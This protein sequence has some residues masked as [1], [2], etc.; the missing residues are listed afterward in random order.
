MNDTEQTASSGTLLADAPATSDQLG[1]AYQRIAQGLAKLIRTSQGGKCVRLDGDWGAGKSTVIAM[2]SGLLDGNEQERANSGYAVFQFDAWV[3]AGD[4]LKLAFLRSLVDRLHDKGWLNPPSGES[5]TGKNARQAWNH[6]LD[7][8]AGKVKRTNETSNTRF[9][10]DTKVGVGFVLAGLA[11]WSMLNE[12]VLRQVKDWKGE[13]GPL[14]YVLLLIFIVFACIQLIPGRLLSLAVKLQADFKETETISDG[15]MTS[16][17]FQDAFKDLMK[18]SLAGMTRAGQKR[19]LIIVVDNLD[20]V[21]AKQVGEIW[22]LLRSFL[23]NPAFVGE[24]WFPHLWVIVPTADATRLQPGGEQSETY[25][26]KA[27]QV[28]LSLPQPMLHSWKDYLRKKL[29]EA[30]PTSSAADQDDIL[31]IFELYRLEQA[32]RKKT[33][34]PVSAS[35]DHAAQSAVRPREI[36]NFV[37]DLVALHIEWE[38]TAHVNLPLLAA[39]CLAQRQAGASRH[40]PPSPPESVISL[41][42]QDRVGELMA[43]LH[44]HAANPD[45]ASYLLALPAIETALYAGDAQALQGRLNRGMGSAFVLSMYLDRQLSELRNAALLRAIQACAPIQDPK[46]SKVLTEKQK[47]RM[48]AGLRQNLD[49]SFHEKG[50]ALAASA[51]LD[52]FADQ[53]EDVAHLLIDAFSTP[54]GTQPTLEFVIEG[55]PIKSWSECEAEF[56]EFLTLE[57][58]KRALLAP[59]AQPLYW[60]FSGKEWLQFGRAAASSDRQWLAS[61]VRPRRNLT[62]EKIEAYRLALADSN[63]ADI[64]AVWDCDMRDEAFRRT[65]LSALTH[66]LTD[67][68][69]S[70]GW[71]TRDKLDIIQELKRLDEAFAREVIVEIV[72]NIGVLITRANFSKTLGARIGQSPSD[73]ARWLILALWAGQSLAPPDGDAKASGWPSTQELLDWIRLD[74]HHLDVELHDRG[75]GEAMARFLVEAGLMSVLHQNTDPQLSPIIRTLELA[76][77]ASQALRD[78][79]E[80]QAQDLMTYAAANIPDAE[81]RENL[82]NAR[83]KLE[84]R[85][86]FHENVEKM[87]L[88]DRRSSSQPRPNSPS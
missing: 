58:V 55:H 19:Q 56:F 26:E 46:G 21:D 10:K 43:M 62:D 33:S 66:N 67:N 54:P 68:D 51:V 8:L 61:V 69:L 34:E 23:D 81:R 13:F 12:Q 44:F 11:V 63:T 27:F 15:A 32:A 39:Y 76:L 72:D 74:A 25:L 2:L 77:G 50:I 1:G 48:L 36:L 87:R 5:Q 60:D 31:R 37:N 42:H 86:R 41:L 29:Q 3:H 59:D 53:Q 7:I 80:A 83:D 30:F 88:A 73:S 75:R 49:L 17:E 24:P 20:R 64:K 57:P 22:T 18:T 6:K 78:H 14:I 82:I 9:S 85:K 45:E 38:G 71:W 79:L 40:D 52:C 16:V 47:A 35:A 84:E 4:P 70:S 65:I 28:R